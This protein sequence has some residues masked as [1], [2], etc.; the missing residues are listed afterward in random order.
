MVTLH[1]AQLNRKL[2]RMPLTTKME[3]G[4][5][6]IDHHTMRTL[7][8]WRIRFV[9]NG[10]GNTLSQAET[11]RKRWLSWF[12]ILSHLIEIP[13][14][15]LW[16]RPQKCAG[17]EIG[18][19]ILDFCITIYVYKL[20]DVFCRAVSQLCSLNE[21]YFGWNLTI[22]H[23]ICEIWQNGGFW[24]VEM[25]W[26]H[27]FSVSYGLKKWLTIEHCFVKREWWGND[28][29]DKLAKNWYVSMGVVW[30]SLFP[31]CLVCGHKMTSFHIISTPI[32]S[33]LPGLWLQNSQKVTKN[34]TTPRY[35]YHFYTCQHVCHSHCSHYSHIVSVIP[36]WFPSF[37]CD[38]HVV[39]V[40]ST[41]FPLCIFTYSLNIQWT[42]V[43]SNIWELFTM[44]VKISNTWTMSEIYKKRTWHDQVPCSWDQF[45]G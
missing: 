42:H 25:G 22:S 3:C 6:T 9:D 36:T 29:Y 32:D 7:M 5:R 8:Q 2:E 23:K 1:W 19:L 35:R 39:P 40:V 33:C 43:V 14:P 24:L 38:F 28:R 15:P 44:V 30:K 34:W 18:W 13:D 26:S 16:R 21:K 10:G 17:D 27:D 11:S 12:L 41:S 20:L 37:I 45:C 4:M 31:N